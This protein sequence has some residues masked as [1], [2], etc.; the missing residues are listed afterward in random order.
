[1]AVVEK[2]TDVRLA[3]TASNS[4]PD[5]NSFR[6]N[7]TMLATL[8]KRLE[9]YV[10]DYQEKI[11]TSSRRTVD[12]NLCSDGRLSEADLLGIYL[13]ATEL[14]TMDEEL[15]SEP[16][17]QPNIPLE[18]LNSNCCLISQPEEGKTEI[19]VCDPYSIEQQAYLFSRIHN[20]TT[21]FFL[22][23][24]STIERILSQLSTSGLNS[25]IKSDED[26]ETL[27]SLAGEAKIV[28]L[29]NE[30]FSRATEQRAS[31]IHIEPEEKNLQIRFRIDGILH[32]Y[33]SCPLSQAPAIASRIKLLSGLN[34]AENRLPQDGRTNIRLGGQEIDLRTSTI[35]TILGESIVLRILRKEALSFDL[36]VIGMD[37]DTEQDFEQMIKAPHGIILVV[38][39]TGSGKTTTL[40]S[41]MNQLNDH[42]RKIITIEDPVEYKF[43]GMSQM[44]VNPKIG[45]TFADGLRHIV[46]QDPDIILVGEIRDNE[47]AAIA[48]NAAL[49]G[50]LVFS[51]LH[52]N[53]AAGAISRLVDMGVENFLLASALHGVLSQRLVRTICQTCNGSG[54]NMNVT[55]NKCRKCSGTGF[56][57]RTGIFELLNVN[58]N[59]RQAIM[60]NASSTEIAEL[61]V[62]N[63][64][65]PLND[66]GQ[67]KVDQGMTTTTEIVKS[68]IDI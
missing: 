58:E 57:G 51:T 9:A 29:V 56:F 14:P 4:A 66:A 3:Y 37:A 6:L 31:D 63:G 45:L 30:M 22:V 2:S 21:T 25:E 20:C 62:T 59:I 26:E 39:P 49:T 54:V 19:F 46:R 67:R 10:P 17:I 13:D 12:W 24:R 33:I 18:Y 36:K 44:Q 43:T 61:A 53:D 34:I 1:M 8:K 47:T 5:G 38:G 68:T 23:R 15:L 65:I 55:G 11:A 42:Q 52:T 50:H 32:N 48:I 60:R 28:R 7:G 40:Y 64:M 41:V 16:E 27:R 35:P